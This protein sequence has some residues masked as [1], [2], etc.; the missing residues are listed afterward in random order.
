MIS[1]NVESKVRSTYNIYS[2]HFV[3]TKTT[4]L[5]LNLSINTQFATKDRGINFTVMSNSTSKFSTFKLK[6]YSQTKATI[7]MPYVFKLGN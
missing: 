5:L 3:L 7:F 2:H 6:I 1:V 4:L